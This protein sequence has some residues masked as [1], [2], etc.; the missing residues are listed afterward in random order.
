MLRQKTYHSGTSAAPRS[1]VVRRPPRLP[2]RLGYRFSSATVPAMDWQPLVDAARRARESAYAPH[3]GYRVG[4]ALLTADGGI[5]AASNVW[6]WLLALSICAERAAV[7]AAVNAGQRDFSALA[8][9][10]A[11]QPPACPCGLCR[12]TLASS[13]AT[14]RSCAS[15]R[16][17]RASKRAS[18]R[19]SPT[20]SA[21]TR[22]GEGRT[23]GG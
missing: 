6:N 17:A 14:C 21:S 2:F 5:F 22:R 7:T 15:T 11:S 1:G 12:Q 23:D 9:V 16:P 19:S 18:R 8:V 3:S 20:P 4:A 13:A 10:T